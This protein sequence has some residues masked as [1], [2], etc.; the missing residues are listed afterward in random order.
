MIRNLIAVMRDNI[1][2]DRNQVILFL[3]R[4]LQRQQRQVAVSYRCVKKFKCHTETSQFYT[5]NTQTQLY[6]LDTLK[7]IIHY[8]DSDY[9]ISIDFF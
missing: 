2:I 3:A 4:I 6:T 5:R 7:I 9:K 8:K 1:C